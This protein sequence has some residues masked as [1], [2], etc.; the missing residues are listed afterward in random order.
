MP[1]PGQI[2]EA[3]LGQIPASKQRGLYSAMHG[4]R[5]EM[6]IPAGRATTWPAMPQGNWDRSFGLIGSM[7][8]NPPPVNVLP[9]SAPASYTHRGVVNLR[10]SAD[11]GTT[12]HEFEH[13]RQHSTSPGHIPEIQ[14]AA[15]YEIGPTILSNLMPQA[16]WQSGLKGPF[17][18][19]EDLKASFPGGYSPSMTWMHNQAQERGVFGPTAIAQSLGY[20]GHGSKSITGLIDK[21]PQWTKTIAGHHP[22]G[23]PYRPRPTAPGQPD[24]RGLLK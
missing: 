22:T 21:S 7:F 1:G 24:L 15:A 2:T 10:Q 23:T 18:Q 19:R 12:A 17:N 16:S 6:G 11:P 4:S 3:L 8:P 14:S 9:D 13:A 20:K 5:G